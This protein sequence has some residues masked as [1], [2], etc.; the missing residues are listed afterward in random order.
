VV[1]LPG[2]APATVVARQIAAAELGGLSGTL[3]A[4]S[5]LQTK[6]AGL[7]RDGSADVVV[8]AAALRVVS[9]R[10]AGLADLVADRQTPLMWKSRLLD[11]ATSS[12]PAA[13]RQLRDTVFK[14]APQRVQ[15][16]VAL[17]STGNA[18]DA[19]RLVSEMESGTVAPALLRDRSLQDKLQKLAGA[20]TRERL[21]VLTA[22]L[23]DMDASVQRLIDQRRRDYAAAKVDLAQGRQLYTQ[24]CAVCHQLGGQGALVGPQLDGIGNRGVERLCEDVLDPNRNVDH[25]FVTTVLTLKS[26]GVES[27]LFRRE[28]GA[29]LVLANT[30]GQEFAVPKADVRE[31]QESTTSLMPANFG[32]A[33]TVEQFCDLLGFLLE[34]RK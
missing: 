2:V 21:K 18:D 30:A 20:E 16:R 26:G 27:G 23:P 13:L 6:L 17:L 28:E 33:L 24:L 15:V 5:P 25:A 8:R 3:A 7:M 31:R 32:E 9:P 14:E 4:G 12:D 34:Q 29:V 10:G 19:M 11:A 22:A 1:P